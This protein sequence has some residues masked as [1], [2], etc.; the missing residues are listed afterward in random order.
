M[1]RWNN[2]NLPPGGAHCDAARR[3]KT[4]RITIVN[5]GSHEAGA[6]KVTPDVA[7]IM[8]QLPPLVESLAGVDIKKLVEIVPQLESEKPD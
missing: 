1:I 8:A 3:R 2:V 7:D 5:T 4:D 6:S